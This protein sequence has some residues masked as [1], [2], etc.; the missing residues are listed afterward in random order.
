MLWKVACFFMVFQNLLESGFSGLR[1]KLSGGTQN[2]LWIVLGRS[3]ESEELK[4]ITRIFGVESCGLINE[5]YYFNS[6]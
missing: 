1:E 2:A 6:F 5:E 4:A 3:L